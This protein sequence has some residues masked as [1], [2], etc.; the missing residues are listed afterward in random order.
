[1]LRWGSGWGSQRTASVAT[2]RLSCECRPTWRKQASSTSSSTCAGGT[3]G[4]APLWAMRECKRT[5]DEGVP[6]ADLYQMLADVTG[7]D[8]PGGLLVY[9]EGDDEAGLPLGT[10]G[11]VIQGSTSTSS[12]WI[13]PSRSPVWGARSARWGRRWRRCGIVRRTAVEQAAHGVVATWWADRWEEQ[14][15]RALPGYGV[16]PDTATQSPYGDCD[17]VFEVLGDE[18]IHHRER[19]GS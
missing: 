19:L 5:K 2:I 12:R 3:A 1:M 9:A 14:P 8:L 16:R 18:P 7:L 15:D 4:S 13:S 11:F 17:N 6:N 10:I